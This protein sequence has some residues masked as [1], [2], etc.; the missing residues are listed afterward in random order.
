LEEEEQEEGWVGGGGAEAEA[1]GLAGEE[2]VLRRWRGS[3]SERC[4]RL[5]MRCW[6][7]GKSFL[8]VLVL[9]RGMVV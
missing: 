6:C 5:V 7:R 3:E 8:V 4:L 1:R 9:A 2:G